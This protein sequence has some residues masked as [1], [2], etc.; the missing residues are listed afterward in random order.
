MMTSADSITAPPGT[1]TPAPEFTGP[2]KKRGGNSVTW[3]IVG[4][5]V[6]IV[7]FFPVLWMVITS[8]KT[9]AQAYTNTPTVVFSPT[10]SQ[11]KAV[12]SSGLWPYVAN[13]AFA[14]IVSTILVLLLATPCAFA[15][16][17]RPV[18]KTRDVLFFFISTKML[19]VVAAIIP[20]YIAARDL[21]MLDNI[22]TL[23]ILYT[24]MNLPIAVWML[25]SFLLEV[26]GELLEA[27]EMDGAPLRRT[28]TEVILPVV[29]P[30]LA[31]TA[32]ICCI[33]SWNEFFFA[34][35]ITAARAATVP[36]FLVGFISS[37][38]LYFAQLAAAAMVATLPV[39]LAGWVAQ[40]YLVRGLSFGAIK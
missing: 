18:R 37:E 10:L 6:G 4:W 24:A 36:V 14:T 5:V 30:G 23:V 35:N 25:R 38:G 27:A 34:V 31:A 7:F 26:P 19:P 29:A 17:L 39:I 20:I 8:F 1:T 13:S 21:H 22:F 12:F 15:L 3:G 9:E 40:R 32:L 28:V 2:R 33:F 16:S 11:Y